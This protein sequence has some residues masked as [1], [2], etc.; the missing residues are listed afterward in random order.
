[1]TKTITPETLIL[2]PGGFAI[3][4][5]KGLGLTLP[6][7]AM[8]EI[9]PQACSWMNIG[10]ENA[11]EHHAV[12][13]IGA[14]PSSSFD[15]MCTDG[16]LTCVDP[17]RALTPDI[18]A[19]AH[20]V[21][22]LDGPLADIFQLLHA[23][24]EDLANSEMTEV[25]MRFLD[26]AAEHSGFVELATLPET[27]GLFL[28]GWSSP[29][30]GEK[31]TLLTDTSEVSAV[32]AGFGREDLIAPASGFC[33]YAR[34][35]PS[36]F[37]KPKSIYLWRQN[38]L[39]RLDVLPDMVDP[40]RGAD[41]SEHVRAMVPRLTVADQILSQ[42]K[43]VCRPRFNGEDTLSRF[44][45]PVAVG[46]D[47]VL[48]AEGGLFVTGWMLDPLAQVDLTL[49]KSTGNLYSAVSSVAHSLQR[50]DLL[51]AFASDKRFAGLLDPE[52]TRNGFL[53]FIPAPPDQ[54]EGA[55]VY[56]E[57][58]LHNGQCLF[59]PI[60]P[61]R[62]RDLGA[63]HAV[64]NSVPR[65]D[66]ALENILTNHVAPFLVGLAPR[67]ANNRYQ[68]IPMGDDIVAPNR[69]VAALMTMT[70]P[71]D[72]KPIFASLTN[73]QEAQDLELIVI[74]EDTLDPQ[75][76]SQ[77]QDQFSF[78]GLSGGA[79]SCAK[80]MS[81]AA[82]LDV[83]IR[84]TTAPHILLWCPQALP[85]TEGWLDILRAEAAKL[86]T[87]GLVSPMLSYEDGSIHFG[88]ER[89][90]GRPVEAISQF[91]GFNR[92][93]MNA[94]QKVEVSAG[95]PELALIDRDV[96]LKVGGLAGNLL[97]DKYI[98]HG[99]GARLRDMNAAAWCTPRV[100]FWMLP[101]HASAP[102][103]LKTAFIDSVDSALIAHLAKTL[104]PQNAR[105]NQ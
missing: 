70:N 48:R 88:G 79:L 98:H 22:E 90:E 23:T 83:A 10:W 78:Y 39:R 84:A 53:C 43:R 40:L 69:A 13:M 100:E 64:L 55:E 37:R 56:L 103:N 76:V 6:D 94:L 68:M 19:L 2:L 60:E 59:Q 58:V 77:L 57:L 47:M 21:R 45:G 99:L 89:L 65:N 63:A 75:I 8:V 34:K 104:P 41:A 91:A 30:V 44:D 12:S 51:E 17:A 1:M 28:Q 9:G 102:K 29:L 27:G 71:D 31:Y 66:P 15:V 73:T 50:P 7:Q 38:D 5:F 95:A 24:I 81:Q 92:S 67:I 96:L 61:R 87:P 46:L 32:C 80:Q 3:L 25:L 101:D 85:Q 18:K 54:L 82:R 36:E 105:S 20:A 74:I 93:N 86:E 4:I 35:H 97:G 52:E 16:Q 33:L 49:I 62:C 14:V 11:G 42:F 26:L 72:L